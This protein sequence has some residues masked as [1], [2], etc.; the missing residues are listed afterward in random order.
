MSSIDFETMPSI[1]FSFLVVA[2]AVFIMAIATLDAAITVLNSI[3]KR[4]LYEG[5]ESE[6]AEVTE[7]AEAEEVTEDAEAEEEEE[8]EA[9]EEEEAEEEAE[10]EVYRIAVP[11]GNE[12]AL[13]KKGPHISIGLV[14]SGTGQIFRVI[15]LTTGTF[16]GT[17]KI[18]AVGG[19][20]DGKVLDNYKQKN[21]HLCLYKTSR[22][23]NRAQNWKKDGN[24]LISMTTGKLQLKVNGDSIGFSNNGD[25]IIF[26]PV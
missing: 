20:A 10:E 7:D 13:K 26:I 14:E 1:A 17:I 2:V 21:D 19:F 24:K 18:Q 6:D 5:E 16:A 15:P 12:M 3:K 22:D 4:P 9:E 25:D 11:S 23:N 8:A